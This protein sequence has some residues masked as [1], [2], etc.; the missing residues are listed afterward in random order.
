MSHV[1]GGDGA[2]LRR[3]RSAALVGLHRLPVLHVLEGQ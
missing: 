3:P 1:L 2:V